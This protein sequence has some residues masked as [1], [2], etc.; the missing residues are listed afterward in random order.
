MP[1]KLVIIDPGH[2][3][4]DP[5]AVGQAGIKEKDINLK[6]ALLVRS[7]LEKSVNIQMTRT[8]DV[9]LGVNERQDLYARIDISNKLSAD[10]FVSIHC[11]SAEDH[12][13]N[14]TE[15]WCAYPGN[16]SG[17]KLAEKI[18][19]YLSPALAL[20]RRGIKSSNFFVLKETKCPAVIVEIAFISN[21]QEEVLLNTADFQ[22]RAAI[23]IAKGIASF[24]N[25]TIDNYQPDNCFDKLNNKVKFNQ[26][27][28]LDE[29]VTWN[30]FAIILDR[31]GLL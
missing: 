31:L 23:S 26:P 12:L 8:E 9:M 6:I 1:K 11:N 4:N 14:G 5:G 22:N 20:Q 24:L 2:G 21:R 30:E 7:Y 28:G 13:A 15:I 25:V 17:S 18:D 29:F 16:T 10:C 3:G 19:F 27:H